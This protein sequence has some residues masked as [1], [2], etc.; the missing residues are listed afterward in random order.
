MPKGDLQGK[1]ALHVLIINVKYSGK[2]KNYK[3]LICHIID[4]LVPLPGGRRESRNILVVLKKM[5]E[6]EQLQEVH[7]KRRN[8]SIHALAWQ[9]I[10]SGI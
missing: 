7:M 9:E 2:P 4:E 3:K 8:N 10:N 6:P 5:I 1:T